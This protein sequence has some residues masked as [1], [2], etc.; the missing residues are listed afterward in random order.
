MNYCTIYKADM[1][2]GKGVRVSLFVSGC[3]HHCPGCFNAKAWNE[4]YGKPYTQEIEDAIMEY[5]KVP[6]VDGLTFLGGEPMEPGHQEYVWKLISRVRSELPDKNI[7]LYSGWT[8]EELR[9][10]Q[11]PYVKQI[12]SSVDVLVDGRFVQALKDPDIAFRGSSNQRVIDMKKTG[13][14][15]PVLLMP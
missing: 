9:A 15:D 4:E 6:Y 11:T 8:L 1:I 3:S 5:L 14:G 12:R 2:N 7:W 10:M 13:D